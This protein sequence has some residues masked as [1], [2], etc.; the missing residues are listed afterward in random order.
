MKSIQIDKNRILKKFD[1]GIESVIYYYDDN[2]SIVLLK[3]FNDEIKTDEII[4]PITKETLLNKEKKIEIIK[5][6]PLFKNE[7][8]LLD[9]AYEQDNFKG[10]T[11]EKSE[12]GASSCFQKTKVKI[13]I[14]KE[15][16]N[17][18]EMFNQNGIFLGDIHEG[19]ILTNKDGSII[20]LCDLDN[21]RIG[22][23]DFDI[24]S[25]AVNQ[26]NKKCSNK[27]LIDC[28]SFNLFTL[29]FLEKIYGPHI[30]GYLKDNG[31]PRILNTKENRE[32][33]DS[34]LNLD[35]SYQKKYLIDNIK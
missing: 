1:K 31:L 33:A 34:I 12:H 35:N 4:I 24:G 23:F 13:K 21:L 5:S 30:L 2:G 18:I 10:Y 28:Y 15:L 11:L 7:V 14:L 20:Q 9:K 29:C 26:F 16:R 19:N 27:D 17:K 22:D 8:K 3:Y 6:S 25:N 32:I